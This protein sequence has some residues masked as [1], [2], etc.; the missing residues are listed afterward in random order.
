[1]KYLGEIKELYQQDYGYPS[2]TSLISDQPMEHKKEILDYL[3]KG[4]VLAA[5]AGRA[6]DV[7]SGEFIPTEWLTLTDGEYEWQ[8]NLIFYVEK[9]NLKL[10]DE[11]V[12]HILSK[13]NK[14]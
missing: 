11:I 8:T 6:R 3:K 9:Y 7:I 1:M 12:K 2:I 10:P 14:A 13:K 4:E 5:A